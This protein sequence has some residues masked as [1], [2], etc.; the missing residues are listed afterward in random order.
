MLH[1]KKIILGITGGIAAYKCAHLVRLLVKEGAEVKVILTG[2]AA[3]FVTPQT[4]SVLSKNEVLTDFFDPAFNWNNH[5]HLAEWADVMLIAPLTANTLA[6]M[7]SG[8][9]D[10]ILL[11]AYLS[12]RS[13]TIVAPAMDLDMYQHPTVKKNLDTLRSY[14]NDIIPAETGELASGLTGEGRMAEPETIVSFLKDFFG[15]DLPLKGRSALV[16]AGP[17]YEAIDP[18]RYIGNR[19]SGKMG[20]ALAEELCQNGA[21]VTLVLGPGN[22]DI[23]HKTITVLRVE[24]SDEMFEATVSNY[25]NKDIVICSAAVSDYRPASVS[26]TK[27]KKKDEKL[28]LEL[29]RTKDILNE[30]GK[31][32]VKQCLVGFALETNNIL[33][34]AKQKLS[35]KNLDLVVANSASEP[36][37]GFGGDTN[38]ITI[39]DKHNKITK[40]ELKS[41][42]EVAHDIVNYIIEFIK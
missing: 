16:N 37:S 29:T 15:K 40:F 22:E 27:I 31:Q 30:L 3:Q 41:K 11:A 36:G 25:T 8:V 42:R 6:K 21:T 18:V 38:K 17:T 26:D 23:K 4:L 14:G 33:E 2:S 28:V 5:V 24:S 7:S 13:K 35:S 10:N 19:S 32:K 1:R 9:C 12:A 39:I 20:I 34:Y